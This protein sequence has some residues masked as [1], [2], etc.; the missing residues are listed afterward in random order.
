MILRGDEHAD[1]T[2]AAEIM[3]ATWKLLNAGRN[4]NDTVDLRAYVG[5]LREEKAQIEVFEG[6]TP[7]VLMVRLRGCIA[8]G[9]GALKFIEAWEK[10]ELGG[11]RAHHPGN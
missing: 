8:L 7:S 4:L 3:M 1:L 10:A 6:V 9:E 2:P 5:R 11:A